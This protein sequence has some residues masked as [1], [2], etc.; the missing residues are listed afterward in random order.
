MPRQSRI[1]LESGKE[2][3]LG[4]EA[5]GSE[6]HVKR[7]YQIRIITFLG[8]PELTIAAIATGEDNGSDLKEGRHKEI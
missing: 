1:G 3:D 2:M 8:S 4:E 5:S 7:R 6:A